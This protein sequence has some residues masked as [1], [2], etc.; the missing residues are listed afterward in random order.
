M[1][2]QFL[3]PRWQHKDPAVRARAVEQLSLDNP[4]HQQAL[5]TLARGDAAATVRQ[6]AVARLTDF[7]LLDQL[8]QADRDDTIREAAGRQISRLLAGTA[9]H[10]PSRENRLRLIGLTDNDAALAYVAEHSDDAGCRAAAAARVSNPNQLLQLA[11]SGRDEPTRVAATERLTD[12]DA[13][14]QLVRDGRDKR[15]L[16]LAR[17]RLKH[18]NAAEHDK[19][20]ARDRADTLATEIHAHRS[21]RLD[22]LYSARLDQLQ[23]AWQKVASDADDA[24]QAT[25]NADIQ[26]CQQRIDQQQQALAQEQAQQQASAELNEALSTLRALQQDLVTES[27][28]DIN[29]LRALVAT[30]H[31]RWQAAC[32]EVQAS[33]G[34]QQDAD[35]LFAD[36]QQCFA[37]FDAAQDE[38]ADPVSLRQQWPSGFALPEQLACALEDA[39]ARDDTPATPAPD[40]ALRKSL[41]KILATLQRELRQRNLKHAN[42]LWRKAEALLEEDGAPNWQPR[43][44][45]LRP[46]MDELRDWHAFAAEPKKADLCEQMEALVTQTMDVEEKATAIHALHDAWRELMSADQESDQALWDRFRTASDQAYAP[47]REHFRELD[48]QKAANMEKRRA[49]LEQLQGYVDSQ[50]WDHANWQQVFDIRRTAPKEWSSH[51]P[52]DFTRGRD[53]SRQFSALLKLLDEKLDEASNRHAE[54]LEGLIADAATLTEGELPRNSVD[55]WKALQQRW[56]R[57]DWVHPNRFRSLH[58][59]FRKLGDKLFAQLDAERDQHK[60][61]MQA[62]HD[63]LKAA[64]ASLQTLIKADNDALDLGA[65]QKQADAVAELPCPP[66]DKALE[67]QR[68]DLI[69]RVRGLRTWQQAWQQWQQLHAQVTS[70]PDADETTAQRQLAVALE[71]AADCASPDDAREERMQWQLANLQK[72][73]RGANEERYDA[74]SRLLQ[75]HADDITQGLSSG[76]RARLVAVLKSLEPKR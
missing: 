58:R 20:Q 36:W 62:Q 2:G 44:E 66:R 34:Q 42:R 63:A 22:N 73:M 61:A 9:E 69:R 70:S 74:V 5:I 49:L 21:R 19:Q 11:L 3:K 27:W 31:N 72:A 13:L 60:Q 26:A 29:S 18:V 59:K 55:Q 67:N 45:K 64:L 12:A 52:I 75:E 37:L 10:S 25:V 38:H 4:E 54:A 24:V 1:F 33:T 32:E 57:V 65:I 68:Q 15:V 30:Q 41:T 53:L 47:C 8:Q 43:L 17:E 35:T 6:A 51:Q 23:Q 28:Q 39:P 7:K 14:R 71:A 76:V 56:G 48:A 40:N 46:Q 16:R 50:D